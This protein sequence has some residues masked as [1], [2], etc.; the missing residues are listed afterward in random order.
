LHKMRW[1][2]KYLVT[3]EEMMKCDKNTIEKI[4]LPAIVLMERAA[5]AVFNEIKELNVSDVFIMAGT[6]NNGGDGLALARLLKDAGIAVTVCIA[7]DE[8]R[9]SEQWKQEKEILD[10]YDVTYSKYCD[11]D[12][13][14]YVDALFGTG[15]RRQIE[16]TCKKLIEECNQRPGIKIAVDIPSGVNPDDGSIMGCA[17]DAD[18]TV[19]FAYAKR[20]HMLY[21]GCC[22]TGRLIVADVGIRWRENTAPGM[23]YYDEPLSEL[24]PAR[25]ACGNKGTFGKAL[26][27]A[28]S[29]NMAGAAVLA[30]RACYHSG[31]G[32]VKVLS[33]SDNRVIIQSAVPEAL[34]GTYDNIINSEKWADVIAIGPGLGKSAEALDILKKVITYSRKPLIIDADGLNLIAQNDDL[35]EMLSKQGRDKR[36]IIL[37]PHVGEMSRLMNKDIDELK[38]HLWNYGLELAESLNAVVVVKDARTF[39]CAPDRP[40]CINIRGNSGMATAGSGDVLTGCIAGLLAQNNNAYKAASVAVYAAAI[41]GE[42]AADCTSE[43]T[44]TALDIAG[45]L[46]TQA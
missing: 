37:T 42:T 1:N 17:F 19:T 26:L 2:M 22:H 15:L 20:G 13:D 7:G 18:I 12:Y 24:L 43:Y 33:P 30:A 9:A 29:V 5:L 41:A 8:S 35:R 45:Y 34:L 21:P 40:V 31:A 3:S 32:M 6:G 4:K 25:M 14:V 39:V 23:F 27:I 10:F 44:V 28:G 36:Q 11:D 16:G 38:K 46:M